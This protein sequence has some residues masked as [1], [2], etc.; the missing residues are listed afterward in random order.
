MTMKLFLTVK[1]LTLIFFVL[2]ITLFT[3]K[4]RAETIVPESTLLAWGYHATS[5]KYPLNY[6]DSNVENRQQ[7]SAQGIRS[8]K[9]LADDPHTYYRY[10]VIRETFN[11][12][13]AA[14]DR[15]S[16]FKQPSRQSIMYSKTCE[17]RR[18]FSR[19][20]DVY[21]IHT[22]VSMFSYNE[23]QRLVDLLKTYINS[24]KKNR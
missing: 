15:V 12:D 17:L 1:C 2:S 5:L 22:D 19:E 9:P 6:C 11:S 14:I 20:K 13:Q 4:I 16:S 21:I 8:I 10:T 18:G 23:Q 7:R 3:G 24:I